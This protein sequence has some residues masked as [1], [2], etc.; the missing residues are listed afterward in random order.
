MRGIRHAVLYYRLLSKRFLK[1]LS[2]ILLLC[3]VPVLALCL[4][5]VSEQNSGMLKIALCVEDPED[6][7]VRKLVEDLTNADS[8]M[9]CFLAEGEEAARKMVMSGEVDAAWIFQ[10]GFTG[11]IKEMIANGMKGDGP[12][13]VVEQ[14]DNVVLQLARIK[15]FGAIYP[16]LSYAMF[17]DFVHSDLGVEV[18]EEELRTYYEA[19]GEEKDLFRF[20]TAGAN[21]QVETPS[22]YMIAPLRGMLAIL[23]VLCGFAADMFFLQDE[24]SGVLDAF[25]MRTRRRNIYIYQLAAM[26]PA[27]VAVLTAL[28]LLGDFTGTASELL[29]MILYLA[30]CMVFCNLIRCLCGTAGCLG[31]GIPILTLGMLV[32]CPVFFNLRQLHTVQ[33]LLPPYY[34]LG[35]ARVGLGSHEIAVMALF[36][37]IGAAMNILAEK[38]CLILKKS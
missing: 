14:E 9:K 37:V 19:Y 30:D 6:E 38:T 29:L 11:R 1:K 28:F 16:T 32:V 20:A 8:V 13:L 26:V 25:S 27:A 3:A 34:Y 36:A 24:T 4:R 2:F 12:I 7:N 21:T 10:K 17:Q 15:L 31:A 18:T 22:N 33:Y 35:A 5:N 23:I